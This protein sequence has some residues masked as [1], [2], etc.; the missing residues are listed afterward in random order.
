[1]RCLCVPIFRPELGTLPLQAAGQLSTLAKMNHGAKR[2]VAQLARDCRQFL[3]ARSGS[4]CF[5]SNLEKKEWST[6]LAKTLADAIKVR[7]ELSIASM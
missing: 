6:P 3:I 5:A 2:T 7:Q 1:M 4:R